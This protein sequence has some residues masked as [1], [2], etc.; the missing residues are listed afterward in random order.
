M[1]NILRLRKLC[2]ILAGAFAL[3]SC[4]PDHKEAEKKIP[5][6]VTFTEHIAPLLYQ[7]CTVCHRPGG[8]GH[9]NLVTYQD[10]KN[11]GGSLT[12]VVRQ[13]LMPPWPADPHYTEFIGQRTLSDYDIA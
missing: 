13:R 7:N 11:Y 3:P 1:K 6:K 10:A 2:F 4:N 5:E 8:N 9:F 12:Y